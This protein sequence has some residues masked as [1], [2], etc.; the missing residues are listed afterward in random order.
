[1]DGMHTRYLYT[2]YLFHI[3]ATAVSLIDGGTIEGR[4]DVA[5]TEASR[6]SSADRETALTH[7]VEAA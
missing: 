7:R 2:Y 6:E 5:P 4:E 1:M 3:P